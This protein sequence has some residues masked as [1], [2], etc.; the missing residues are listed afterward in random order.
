MTIFGLR[1][2]FGV[3]AVPAWRRFVAK[4]V[5]AADSHDDIERGE[6][7][8]IAASAT[9]KVSC[10]EFRAVL[11]S[12]GVLR[13]TKTKMRLNHACA[14][15]IAAALEVMDAEPDATREDWHIVATLP[16][17]FDRKNLPEE[18]FAT[19]AC[20]L[21]L[22]ESA[23]DELWLATPYMDHDAI[24]FLEDP[25]S[26]ALR[27]GAALKILTAECNAEFVEVLTK[28]IAQFTSL[29]RL[30]VWEAPTVSSL[31]GT[32]AKAIV[33]DRHSAYLGSANLTGYGL[34]RHFELGVQVDGPRVEQIG[35]ILDA[36]SGEGVVRFCGS[37]VARVV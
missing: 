20:I 27:E 23:H 2:A 3:P 5:L 9:S 12:L 29:A 31:L 19:K 30:T 22:I 35:K 1:E 21:S 15:R 7:E 32:H 14:G 10:N 16:Y 28:G 36:I 11:I 34:D 25:L 8:R 4:M 13:E 17:H 26:A 24:Q 37:E 6:F 18:I 33:A